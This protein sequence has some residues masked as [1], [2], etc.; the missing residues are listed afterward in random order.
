M[1]IGSIILRSFVLVLLI[2]IAVMGQEEKAEMPE[3][4][5]KHQEAVMKLHV[6]EFEYWNMAYH[7]Q[8]TAK[9]FELIDFPYYMG[10]RSFERKGSIVINGLSYKEDYKDEDKVAFQSEI[11][12]NMNELKQIL[13]EEEAE[14]EKAAEADSEE[15]PG[16][17]EVETAEKSD[18]S[19]A[20]GDLAFDAIRNVQV[21][22]IQAARNYMEKCCELICKWRKINESRL[23]ML[24]VLRSVELTRTESGIYQT[25]PDVA[26]QIKRVLGMI[27]KI[28]R[29]FDFTCRVTMESILVNDYPR[30]WLSRMEKQLADLQIRAS[31]LIELNDN[32]SE[33]LGLGKIDRSNDT[34][35]YQRI[36][37][38][39][40]KEPDKYER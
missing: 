13:K 38:L 2:S 36:E 39:R 16:G 17:T 37:F 30:A 40:I 1:H 29:N 3:T 19:K 27:A 7:P 4:E 25:A 21:G 15:Q 14:K 18:M 31:M 8:I 33:S 10:G 12:K 20:D 28:N 26:V 35:P 9:L 22:D 34:I 5:G 24:E 23:F 11:L 6:D 32:G